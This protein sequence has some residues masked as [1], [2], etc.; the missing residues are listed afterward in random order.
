MKPIFDWGTYNGLSTLTKARL[1]GLRLTEI[2]P[3]DFMRR[4]RG[5]E[6]FVKYAQDAKP[7]FATIT[8][9]A[10]YYDP[11]D[12]DG[13]KA[14]KA[15]I[16]RAEKAGAQVYNLHM[17]RVK[18]DREEALERVTDAVKE[19][20]KDT[21][22]IVITLETTY[23]DKALGSLEDIRTVVESIGSERVGISLQLENDFL[24]ETGALKTGNIHTIDA[25]TD[26]KFWEKLFKSALPL[27]HSFVSLRF[28]Q[29]TGIKRKKTIVKKRTPLGMGYPRIEPLSK[30]LAR[31]IVDVFN[32][33][34]GHEIHVIY[35]GPPE[36]KYRDTIT[37]Y[38][39]IARDISDI[40]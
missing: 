11:K 17:G 40:I 21:K 27:F 6:Y 33:G 23:T 5:E 28:S 4:D 37:L 10:P 39:H 2:P 25:K 13:L 20:L 12:P 32:E 9:H 18:G 19:L 8:A 35:T 22:S 1:I 3:G 7:A 15:A 14:H 24:R 29:V 30:A 16:V 34:L 38:S 31:F 36:T 26:E